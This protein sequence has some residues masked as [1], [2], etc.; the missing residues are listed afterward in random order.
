MKLTTNDHKKRCLRPRRLI[1]LT[2]TNTQKLVRGG[3]NSGT[4][5][6]GYNIGSGN[7]GMGNIG[8]NNIGFSTGSMNTGF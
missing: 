3:Y 4:D 2:S 6:V 5:N 1:K 7:I 8:N